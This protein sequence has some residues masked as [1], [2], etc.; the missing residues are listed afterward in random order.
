MVVF[1][2][3]PDESRLSGCCGDRWASA[4]RAWARRWW[5]AGRACRGT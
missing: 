2:R 5:I 4:R 3:D 1:L